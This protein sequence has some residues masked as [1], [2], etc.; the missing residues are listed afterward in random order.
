MLIAFV[1][2]LLESLHDALKLLEPLMLA[3]FSVLLFSQQLQKKRVKH[4]QVPQL[5]VLHNYAQ[6][7]LHVFLSKRLVVELQSGLRAEPLQNRSLSLFDREDDRLNSSS[8][9]YKP[10]VYCLDCVI[11]YFH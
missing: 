1:F 11:P 2:F 3:Q 9:V 8:L 10:N 5:F 4:S 7:L 6:T